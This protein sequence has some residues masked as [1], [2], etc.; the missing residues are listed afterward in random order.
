MTT[1]RD[2]RVKLPWAPKR[3]KVGYCYH[4]TIHESTD[5]DPAPVTRGGWHP[6][7]ENRA[8]MTRGDRMRRWICPECDERPELNGVGGYQRPPRKAAVRTRTGP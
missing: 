1:P 8:G 4:M 3:L 7:S 5:P 2:S 6:C